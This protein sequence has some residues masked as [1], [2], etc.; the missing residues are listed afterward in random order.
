MRQKLN[1]L[2]LWF[3]ESILPHWFRSWL[4]IIMSHLRSNTFPV[5]NAHYN[6]NLQYMSLYQCCCIHINWFGVLW[7]FHSLLSYLLTWLSCSSH[8]YHLFKTYSPLNSWLF[9]SVKYILLNR[10][11][12]IVIVMRY[13][14]WNTLTIWKK[15]HSFGKGILTIAKHKFY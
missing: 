13:K 6:L 3:N 4:T 7:M 10:D 15:N 11:F 8:S 14:T 12:G 1:T 5:R 9:I 2:A